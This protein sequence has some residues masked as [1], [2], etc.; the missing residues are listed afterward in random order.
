MHRN[1]FLVFVHKGTEYR[2]AKEFETAFIE[3]MTATK[4]NNK[5]NAEYK[6]KLEIEQQ[7]FTGKIQVSDFT[8]TATEMSSAT[9][10][11]KKSGLQDGA[12]D[13]TFRGDATINDRD[14]DFNPGETRGDGLDIDEEAVEVT[15]AQ[16]NQD[17][18]VEYKDA[19]GNAFDPKKKFG[20]IEDDALI[21]DNITSS[22]PVNLPPEHYQKYIMD[23]LP[24][25]EGGNSK[26]FIRPHHLETL[27]RHPL[28][29][30]D[31]VMN[32]R[33]ISHY[34]QEFGKVKQVNESEEAIE[35]LE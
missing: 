17:G 28:S 30:K 12:A 23:T 13:Q 7:K 6:R 27:T 14:G 16:Q 11:T 26:W 2:S 34:D 18:V 29:V 31:D 15:Q 8:E 5:F 4:S 32:T 33:Y 19:E 22:Y 21:Y 1:L 9:R 10:V 35:K 20:V 25:K 24:K 3:V